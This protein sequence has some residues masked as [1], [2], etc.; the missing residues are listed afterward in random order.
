MKLE[1]LMESELS[2]E[3]L[4][5][6]AEAETS[7]TPTV[8][9]DELD[10]KP[11][12][13]NN[14]ISDLRELGFLEKDDRM[15]RRQPYKLVFNGAVDLFSKLLFRYFE[16]MHKEEKGRNIEIDRVYDTLT[17]YK[18]A[19]DELKEELKKEIPSTESV[20]RLLKLYRDAIEGVQ[21]NSSHF[22]EFYRTYLLFY[23]L[24]NK[25]SNLQQMLFDDFIEC[26]PAHAAQGN[27]PD[28]LVELNETIQIARAGNPRKRGADAMKA[29]IQ[30]MKSEAD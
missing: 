20:E 12:S 18:D 9:A 2:Y 30:E 15:G 25:E 4:V 8:I 22:S 23:L 19:D 7:L 1:T 6:L 3:I 14:Y 29:S 10:K 11:G 27:V 28:Y 16:I 24:D 21:S 13:I 17:K 26:L 5:M